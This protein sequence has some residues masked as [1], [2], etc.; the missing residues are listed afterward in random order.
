M[1]QTTTFPLVKDTFEQYLASPAISASDIVLLSKSAKQWKAGKD[2]EPEPEEEKESQLI[3]SMVH[4]LVLESKSFMYRY[5]VYDEAMRPVKDKD[6]RNADNKKWKDEYTANAG[7]RIVISKKAA[8]KALAM[9][10]S[11]ERNPAAV[12]LLKG[13]YAEHSFYTKIRT[14]ED[15]D[16][17]AR[18][19]P[20]YFVPGSY[21]VSLKTTKDASP[22]GWKR[23]C[24]NYSY[25]AKE[26]FY[27]R[28]LRKLPPEMRPERGYFIGVE[29]VGP[30]YE[31]VVYDM[32]MG[33]DAEDS[34]FF[35]SGIAKMN[36]AFDRLRD[37]R[38]NNNVRGYDETAENGIML[39]NW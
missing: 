28:V 38:L 33:V 3:G 5:S 30:A 37:L 18:I 22:A 36:L 34:P 32:N 13:G 21:F 10:E 27:M 24:V 25:D 31:T 15:F 20:D 14:H 11:V 9:A 17:D 7:D 39:M 35:Q 8:N 4:C 6:F 2:V 23:Q 29:N 26:A 1:E 16:F 19:R 12:D